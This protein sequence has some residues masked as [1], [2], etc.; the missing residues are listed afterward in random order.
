MSEANYH[1]IA[2]VPHAD[3]IAAQVGVAVPRG[4]GPDIDRG[5]FEL[6]QRGGAVRMVSPLGERPRRQRTA[7]PV[8]R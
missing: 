8:A 3:G 5:G 6:N 2:K 4:D 1:W 7:R